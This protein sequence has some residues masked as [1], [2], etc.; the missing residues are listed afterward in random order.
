M[1]AESITPLTGNPM[2]EMLEQ[3]MSCQSLERGQIVPGVVIRAS[4]SSIIVDVGAKCEG[5]VPADDFARL[6]PEEQADIKPGAD[7]M[8][9]V[10]NIEDDSDNIILSLTR[11]QIYRDWQEAQRL[12]E[13]QKIV[14]SEV[15]GSNKGGVIVNVGRLRGFVPGSQLSVNHNVGQ[16]REGSPSDDRWQSLVGQTL[17]LK[18]IEV[19]QTRNR[20]IMS[21]RAAVRE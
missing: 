19:D 11:A 4:S 15:V 10:V 16:S 2:E 12:L 17:K 13:N 6:S 20:L 5:I 7:V 21:E 18:V 8:V 9:F 1:P 14:E 3:Y